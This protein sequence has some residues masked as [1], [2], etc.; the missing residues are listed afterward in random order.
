MSTKDFDAVVEALYIAETEMG[1]DRLIEA[2]AEA[3]M[4]LSGIN[5]F[6]GDIEKQTS[7]MMGILACFHAD[8][9]SELATLAAVEY[10]ENPT[11]AVH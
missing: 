1:A 4:L 3:R 7:Y 6:H 10:A 9:P 5:R 11:Y 2:R 8:V